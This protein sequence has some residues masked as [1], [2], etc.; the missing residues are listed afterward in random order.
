MKK[1][2]LFLITA[3]LVAQ[4]VN[5]DKIDMYSFKV[6]VDS[7]RQNI[8][9]ED[10]EMSAYPDST[11]EVQFRFDNTWNETIEVDIEATLYDIGDDIIRDKTL[12]ISKGEKKTTVFEYY[13]PSDVR[14]D[15][16]EL[17]V[18]YEYDASEGNQT[19]HYEV[20][21]KFD[22]DIKRRT[23]QTE[24]ILLNITQSLSEEKQKTN[25]L[26]ATVI[27]TTNLSLRLDECNRELT[28]ERLEGDFKKKYE[29]E[30]SRSRNFESQFN[31]CNTEKGNMY[32]MSQVD[33]IKTETELTARREQKN[34]DNTWTFIFV[35][36]VIGYFIYQKKK[37]K[38]GGKGEGVSL[39]GATWK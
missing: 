25:E 22:I 12:S 39:K 15:L 28:N 19:L 3:L 4:A 30:L 9:W 37:E 13:I 6:Y 18:H 1:T 36:G 24:N 8:E 27:S 11:L 17:E 10:D 5:A 23:A 2:I 34:S 20:D 29:E 35:G 14:E 26:L 33:N 16:Y 21:K 32:S 38:T 31:V 7:E